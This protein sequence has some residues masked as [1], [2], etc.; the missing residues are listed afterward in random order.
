MGHI[1][2]INGFFMAMREK[3]TKEGASIH[4]LTVSWDGSKC[5]WEDFR[6][7]VLGATDPTTASEGAL[8]R[9]I[10]DQYKELGLSDVP[11]V[12]DNGVHASASPFEALAERMNWLGAKL[13]DDAF[14]AALLKAGIPED[15][16]MAWTKDPQ[17]ELDGAKVSLFDSLEDINADECV[18]KACKIAGIAAPD[19]VDCPNMAYVFVKPHAVTEAVVK[20]VKEKFEAE[21]ITVSSDGAIDNKTIEKDML[22]DNHYYAIANKASLSKPKDLNPPAAKQEE[23]EKLF[24]LTWPA[25]LEQDLV[26][27][28]VDACAKM[29][30]DGDTMDGIWGKA[31]K[32]GDLVKFGGGFYC[33]KLPL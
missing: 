21:G 14:G 26:F 18:K 16:I 25:A 23:F 8:R 20:L 1:F 29:G 32:A 28:A 15:T 9:T 10:L 13:A 30:V 22:V 7:K 19:S 6:G 24:G 2:A 33:G 5:S 12:G 4:Y 3:Y 11:N 27:N 17:V 31:K